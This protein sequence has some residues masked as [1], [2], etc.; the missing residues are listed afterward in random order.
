MHA[1]PNL[2]TLQ[3]SRVFFCSLYLG[4]WGFV[5]GQ[6]SQIPIFFLYLHVLCFYSPVPG[7]GK[8][9][10]ATLIVC[11]CYHWSSVRKYQFYTHMVNFKGSCSISDFTLKLWELF[12]SKKQILK[13]N[14]I[15]CLTCC[16][17]FGKSASIYILQDQ[18]VKK[19]VVFVSNFN[20][21]QFTLYPW[22]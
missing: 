12:Q 13:A 4:G 8:K 6:P 1:L 18:K 21:K 7:L 19:L 14:Q 9:Y 22:K 16:M 10:L 20:P 15:Y 5:P 17:V 3:H 11:T 2:I